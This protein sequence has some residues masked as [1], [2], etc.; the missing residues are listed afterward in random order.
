M[1]DMNNAPPASPQQIAVT[2][3]SLAADYAAQ[4]LD[5]LAVLTEDGD[6]HPTC[7]SHTIGSEEQSALSAGVIGLMERCRRIRRLVQH[8]EDWDRQVMCEGRGDQPAQAR[9][10]VLRERL[11]SCSAIVAVEQLGACVAALNPAELTK[12]QVTSSIHLRRLADPMGL[13]EAVLEALSSNTRTVFRRTGASKRVSAGGVKRPRCAALTAADAT[14]MEEE[15][16]QRFAIYAARTAL[17]P[18]MYA[19]AAGAQYVCPAVRDFAVANLN[20][21]RRLL[22][23]SWCTHTKA[24]F[25]RDLPKLHGAVLRYRE[26]MTTALSRSSRNNN[27]K[28]ITYFRFP[29]HS[30]GV[31]RVL[32]QHGGLV[33]DLTYD[34]QKLGWRLL[35]LD[36]NLWVPLCSMTS[37]LVTAPVDTAWE[38]ECPERI[39]NGDLAEMNG[40]HWRRV[41][42]AYAKQMEQHIQKAL[43]EGGLDEG[44]I[45]ANRLLCTITMDVIV[46]QVRQLQQS[47][48]VSAL[49]GMFTAD[50]RQGTHVALQL[51][52]PTILHEGIASEGSPTCSKGT[53]IMKF[54]LQGGSVL[55]ERTWSSVDDS[56]TTGVLADD[57]QPLADRVLVD[58]E[59]WLWEEA[60]ES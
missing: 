11:G 58:V 40:Q 25:L 57:H 53:L 21:E 14:Q 48:F 12:P 45:A 44:C 1:S 28:A 30:D 24:H 7:S 56:R 23:R 3:M 49:Q 17:L 18:R 43:Q 52:V 41:V 39:E 29:C 33:M 4:A 15:K 54:T 9:A 26:E 32:L 8:I 46:H 59:R 35:R 38:P 20:A 19:T 36:W 55:Q 27:Q 37:E 5:E 31:I 10:E 13:P 22:R 51:R 34:P 60:M 47:F 2:L 16:R 50:V 6:E 42:P